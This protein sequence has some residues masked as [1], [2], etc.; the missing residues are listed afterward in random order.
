MKLQASARSHD[1]SFQHSTK[2]SACH[3]VMGC[4]E[5]EHSVMLAVWDALQAAAGAAAEVLLARAA[6]VAW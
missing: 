1:V 6:G 4:W 2:H 5:A 3:M